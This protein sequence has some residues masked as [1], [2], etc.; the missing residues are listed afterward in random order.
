MNY[1]KDFSIIV[2]HR[3]SIDTL[4]RLFDS[5]PEEDCI[6]II[7]VDNSPVPITKEEIG[8]NRDYSLFWCDPSR[9][10]GGARNVGIDHAKGRWLLFADADDYYSENAFACFK[11]F[12]DSQVDIV[13]TE[14][15]GINSIT[16]EYSPRGE[17]YVKLVEEYLSG[18][19]DEW[20]I[21][22]HYNS[23]CCKM[24]SHELVSKYQLR[25]D[26]I[27]AGNDAYFSLLTGFYADS[28]AAVPVI[29]YIA[30]VVPGSLTQRKDFA[31]FKSRFEVDM[32]SNQ[33]LRRNNLRSH[34]YRWL[35]S[36]ARS[37]R[38]GLR[39][40]FEIVRLKFKYI[41]PL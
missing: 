26:E 34:Q 15:G 18:K 31:V 6:E 25:Y 27:I 19:S 8:I 40:V 32:R 2:P 23:P 24:V 11:R 10:A 14:M 20:N 4:P 3:N 17:N 12:K 1:S 30:T 13:Y 16:G 29:T 22:L 41:L 5:I 7:L 39:A 9:Y 36:L 35:G 38:Y 28:I 33:F 21:R 37:C